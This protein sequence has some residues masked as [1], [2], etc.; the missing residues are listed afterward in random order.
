MIVVCHRRC[1]LAKSLSFTDEKTRS[2]LSVSRSRIYSIAICSIALNNVRP[3]FNIPRI[4]VVSCFSF[5]TL[6][7][8][9][10]ITVLSSFIP[11]PGTGPGPGP[12]PTAYL[13]GVVVV[14]PTEDGARCRVSLY[15]R[16]PSFSNLS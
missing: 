5:L 3:R 2:T 4:I 14:L 1:S 9:M 11:G 8:L 7:V 13:T 12:C 6:T 16:R 10:V 15:D